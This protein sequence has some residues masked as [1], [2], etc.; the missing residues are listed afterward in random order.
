[1]N[2]EICV[3]LYAV[4][5]NKNGYVESVQICGKF[6]DYPTNV[7]QFAYRNG[8]LKKISSGYYSDCPTPLYMAMLKCARE[9]FKEYK[10]KKIS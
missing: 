5:P 4:I 1:M 3:W 10:G 2:P 9:I 7:I 8:K 6:N